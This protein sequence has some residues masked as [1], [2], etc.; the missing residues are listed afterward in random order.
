[1]IEFPERLKELRKEKGYT[2]K[3]LAKLIGFSYQ[4][5]QK[6]EKGIA[7]P[8]NKNLIKLSE[9][10]GV[11]VSYLL[12]E[13]DVR[14]ASNI[15]EIYEQLNEPR[16]NRV[17]DYTSNQLKEQ[18]EEN[19]IISIPRLVAYYVEEENALSAGDGEGYTS[20]ESKQ[21]V[22]WDKE[23]DYDRAIWIKGDSMEPDF[24]YGEVALIKYQNCYDFPG[25]VCAVDDVERGQA[26][27][28]SVRIIDDYLVLHSLNDSVDDYGNLIFPDKYIPL[29]D[30]PRII[31][32]VVDHFIPIEK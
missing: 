30:N 3:E 13:T 15:Y 31:G 32:K 4:N 12:G 19:N 14:T 27:I 6:Y 5:L 28:K 26:Y 21:T 10:F 11:S 2:Q 7:K 25:Q 22:Y 9:I 20:L 1:M 17:Y 8:L 23:V 18:L 24:H 29:S 16:K